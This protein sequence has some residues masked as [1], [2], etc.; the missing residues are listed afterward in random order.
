MTSVDGRS[1]NELFEETGKISINTN[2]D[3]QGKNQVGRQVYVSFIIAEKLPGCCLVQ[4]L[5]IW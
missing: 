1:C 3:S 2:H 5:F 4:Q